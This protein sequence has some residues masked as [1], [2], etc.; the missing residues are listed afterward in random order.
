MALSPDGNAV[1]AERIA[2]AALEIGRAKSALQKCLRPPDGD[3]SQPSA[4]AR[5]ATA[6][7]FVCGAE[8]DLQKALSGAGI[9]PLVRLERPVIAA[10]EDEIYHE[11]RPDMDEE[12]RDA[13]RA[14]CRDLA[15][16]A[17]FLLDHAGA[18][19]RD[20]VVKSETLVDEVAEMIERGL[21]W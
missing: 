8:R 13:K 2:A 15:S 19:F 6:L 4:D 9:T 10:D 7:G 16:M 3:R 11:E 1:I 18:E 12:E 21:E 17:V 5:T 20:K 14:L